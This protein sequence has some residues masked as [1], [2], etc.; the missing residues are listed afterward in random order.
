MNVAVKIASENE[1]PIGM[2][3]F[4]DKSEL[5]KKQPY[6]ASSVLNVLSEESNKNGGIIC[7]LYDDN[8]FVFDQEF[9]N[10]QADWITIACKVAEKAETSA[11]LIY[12]HAERGVI[13]SELNRAKTLQ[14]KEKRISG[15]D[16]NTEYLGKVAEFIAVL[17]EFY[18]GG[19]SD[20]H[21]YLT[22]DE[23]LVFG[24]YHGVIS[25]IPRRL[26]YQDAMAMVSAVF[27]RSGQYASGEFKA[28]SDEGTKLPD[29]ALP[30]K[31][32]KVDYIELRLHYR[33]LTNGETGDKV[34]AVRFT[35]AGKAR[36]LTD[37]NILDIKTVNV[38]SS[39]MT[40]SSGLILITGP[41]G[42]GKSTLLH[43][44]L[45]E[46]PKESLV[47]TIEDPI[48]QVSDDIL[49]FQ[50]EKKEGEDELIDLVR[51]DPDIIV[52]AEMRDAETAQ[53]ALAMA[54]TGHLVLSTYHA[55]DSLSAIERLF[56]MGVPYSVISQ[57][58]LIKMIT[59]Q[60]LIPVLCSCKKKV[61]AYK[62]GGRGRY[63]KFWDAWQGVASE[64][65]FKRLT[66][67]AERGGLYMKN[68]DG[69]ASCRNTGI[70]DRQLIIEYTVFDAKTRQFIKD[71]NLSALRNDLITR[72]W[73][74]LAE[75]AWN[76]IEEGIT[77]PDLASRQ[78]PDLIIDS[79]SDWEY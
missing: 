33:S 16:E 37:L 38:L 3:Q 74:S 21:F 52:A 62:V 58:S 5:E 13:L 9:R 68:P 8:T 31:E 28:N 36:K 14:K 49:T 69:C 66:A 2:S 6:L 34:C 18:K 75:Q 40:G 17:G 45:S 11:Q 61:S 71:G 51:M 25:F 78:V 70:S 10:E 76:L 24:R 26:K 15:N 12:R 1:K 48:E 30:N 64:A 7:C 42:A 29:V 44:C 47:H 53:G 56:D 27:F 19:A 23:C 59:A 50:G 65:R 46:K 63:T 60:R 57:A 73:K 55:N 35:S 67:L 39:M 43:A 20:V 32:G 4:A 72:G 77:D 79:S 22:G 54:R 41:T